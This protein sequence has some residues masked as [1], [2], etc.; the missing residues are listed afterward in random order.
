MTSKNIFICATG[1][2]IGKTFITSLLLKTLRAQNIKAVG[3]KPIMSGFD[4]ANAAASDSGQLLAAMGQPVTEENI[5][6]ISPWCYTAA[7]SPDMAAKREGKSLPFDEIVR[8]STTA[9]IAQDAE[10]TLIE[11]VGGV[12]VPMDSTHTTR[13]WQAACAD[14]S[15]LVAGTYLGTISHSLTALESLTQA[16][17]SGKN[18]PALILSTSLESPV[19]PEE[20]A[21]VIKQYHPALRIIT[22]ARNAKTAPDALVDLLTKPV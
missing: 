9:P 17:M 14:L 11:G 2:D 22:V 15:I 1:T 18:L 19:P 6:A 3:L 7:L 21:A 10:L 12:M 13:D 5:A 20:T 8:F 16:G 4:A